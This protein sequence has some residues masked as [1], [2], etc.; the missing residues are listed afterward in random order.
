MKR[1]MAGCSRGDG[2]HSRVISLIPNL[3]KFSIKMSI[4]TL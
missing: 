3:E 1:V 4:E 2:D